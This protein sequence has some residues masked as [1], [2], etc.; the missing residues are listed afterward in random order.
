VVVTSHDP[1]S[2]WANA[3]VIAT[4]AGALTFV[5]LY[6]WRTRGAWRVTS[7]GRNVMA[8]MSVILVVS[9]LAVAAIIWGTDWPHRN[10]VRF[11]AWSL[12]AVCIW[13]RV[14]ILW[15]VQHR[16]D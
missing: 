7:V 14:V 16:R 15:R 10:A 2:V 4:F 12:V 6:A 8:L 13:W 11:V 9:A 5:A 1:G 3:A